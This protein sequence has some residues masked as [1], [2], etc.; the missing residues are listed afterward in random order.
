MRLSLR[1]SPSQGFGNLFITWINSIIHSG[2]TCINFNGTNGPY[3]KCKRGLRQGDPLSPL[4]FNLV[5]DVLNK[6][7]QQLQTAGILYGLGNFGSLGPILNLQFADDVLL[8]LKANF[9]MIEALKLHLIAFENLSGM[10]I[11]YD[12]SEMTPPQHNI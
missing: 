9:R 7:L 8:F 10:K 5:V 12:K 6:S 11:N 2:Q 4:L 3:F 1:N